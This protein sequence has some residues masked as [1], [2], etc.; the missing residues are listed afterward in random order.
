VIRY[1]IADIALY[2]ASAIGG[3]EWAAEVGPELRLRSQKDKLE[4]FMKEMK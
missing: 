4:N 2:L 3:P 1:S